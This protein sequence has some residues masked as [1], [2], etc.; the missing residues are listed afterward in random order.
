MTTDRATPG[1][2]ELLCL[3]WIALIW[4]WEPA[5]LTLSVDDSFY[6]L[7]IA[8]H[9]AGGDGFTF[10]GLN[11]TNGFHP[12]WLLT[13]S[14]LAWLVP[15]GAE[16]LM[17]TALTLQVLM[18]W[19]GVVL[20]GRALRPLTPWI[21]IAAAGLLLNFYFVKSLVNGME[22]AL[23][24]LLIAAT[25]AV[26]SAGPRESRSKPL[27]VGQLA[28]LCVM[29]RLEAV[30]FAIGVA[31]LPA[32][33]LEEPRGTKRLLAHP[34]LWLAPL[35]VVIAYLA[36]NQL[37]F[38][39]WFPV[40]S[41][42]KTDRGLWGFGLRR[43]L[44]AV[45]VVAVPAALGLY[46]HR[47]AHDP[48]RRTLLRL[49]APVAFYAIGSAGLYQLMLG[50][51]PAIWYLVPWSTLLIVVAA[52]LLAAAAESPRWRIGVTAVSVLWLIWCGMTWHARLDPASYSAYLAARES[53]WWLEANTAEE[54]L[55]AGW[56]SGITSAHSGRRLM[57]LDGLANSWEYKERY[58]DQGK[59]A[60]FID[61]VWPV[62][63]LAIYFDLENLEYFAE[64]GFRGVPI[65]HW[66]VA[67][68]ECVEFRSIVRPWRS[69]RLVYTVLRRAATD[70]E[71]RFE[72]F[73]V[74]AAAMCPEP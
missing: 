12:L 67:R 69:R 5:Y 64:N 25:M 45:V 52:L 46:L 24:F 53:G 48:A 47:T 66:G 3:A 9:V 23:S 73:V 43:V 61:E 32:D 49:T 35:L 26:W 18:L 21:R 19:G 60:L 29:A 39:H 74:T 72:R 7:Q 10:D 27:V 40:S 1:P 63:Y 71:S 14:G 55:A 37:F 57:N 56:A 59:T 38:G 16:V 70:P 62:D 68:A 15:A 28:G 51:T 13:F 65:G 34:A 2:F 11:S 4:L 36:A 20:L 42:V 50:G 8:R 30:L 6:Y 22:S 33:P 41:A 31:L 54:D 17:R 44:K 58:L